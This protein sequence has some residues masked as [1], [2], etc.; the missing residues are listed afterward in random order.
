MVDNKGYNK[1]VNTFK[2]LKGAEKPINHKGLV[3]TQLR[4]LGFK[5]TSTIEEYKGFELDFFICRQGFNQYNITITKYRYVGT[6]QEEYYFHKINTN[7]NIKAKA[8]K[9]ARAFIDGLKVI[10]WASNGQLNNPNRPYY[11]GVA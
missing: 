7:T 2:D 5:M 9:E 11:K 3:L 6:R 10:D 1:S 4:I 8:R